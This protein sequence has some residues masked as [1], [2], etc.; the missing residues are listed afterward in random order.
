MEDGNSG[1]RSSAAVPKSPALAE[2][3]SELELVHSPPPQYVAP[4]I[5]PPAPE[6][7]KA[8]MAR[9][10]V[11]RALDAK[12]TQQDNASALQAI[13]LAD[14]LA[15]NILHNPDVPKYRQVRARNPAV[16]N[17][18]L[19]VAGGRELLLAMGFGVGV[20]QMEEYWILDYDLKLPDDAPNQPVLSEAHRRMLETSLELLERYAQLVRHKVTEAAT[21][22]QQKL[23]GIDHER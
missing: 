17:K 23:A 21:R 5:V 22:R 1:E 18:L 6:D 8:K 12:I 3:A 11:L 10:G 4:V 7:L 9:E 15:R 2:T 20:H 19:K 16:A 14:K 13:E